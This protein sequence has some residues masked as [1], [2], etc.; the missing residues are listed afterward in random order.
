MANLNFNKVILGGRLTSDPELKQTQSGTTVT[1]FSL[2]VNRRM[3]KDHE[4]K[5]DFISCVAWKQTAEFISRFFHKGSSICVTGSLQQRSWED[6]NG[7][8]RSVVEVVVDEAYFVDSK[9]DATSAPT[10]QPMNY[11][12]DAYK[13]AAPTNFEPMDA[14]SDLPF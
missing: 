2:A 12:P 8:K 11:I 3:G 10:E 5:T 4:Q 6:N 9:N 7:N 14:D 13:P 1:T